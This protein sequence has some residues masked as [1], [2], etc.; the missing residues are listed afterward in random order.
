MGSTNQKLSSSKI[1]ILAGNMD[2]ILSTNEKNNEYKYSSSFQAAK[3]LYQTNTLRSIII[4]CFN[5]TLCTNE[6]VDYDDTTKRPTKKDKRTNL[7]ILPYD[8]RNI[9]SIQNFAFHVI[10][11]VTTGKMQQHHHQQQKQQQYSEQEE[12]SPK[13][14]KT[15]SVWSY[16]PSD[17]VFIYDTTATITTTTTTTTV[18]EEIKEDSQKLC[19][20]VMNNENNNACFNDEQIILNTTTNNNNDNNNKNNNNNSKISYNEIDINVRIHYLG[21]FALTSLLLPVLHADNI[22]KLNNNN[23]NNSEIG[24]GRIVL[25]TS[26]TGSVL[27]SLFGKD[28]DTLLPSLFN[29]N[30]NNNNNNNDDDD[31]T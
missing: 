13:K 6:I 26:V 28:V 19:N 16:S 5:V 3:L 20:N 14:D 30:N 22:G 11:Y 18:E 25:V 1:I 7:L 17:I 9:Q 12:Q 10:Q 4:G 15:E 23:T 27:G 8:A 24:G 21:H 31:D 2:P 29:Y